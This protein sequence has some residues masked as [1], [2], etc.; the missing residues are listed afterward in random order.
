MQTDRTLLCSP[1]K[2]WQENILT[3]LTPASGALQLKGWWRAQVNKNTRAH[4]SPRVI[5]IFGFYL[6]SRS[7]KVWNIGLTSFKFYDLNDILYIMSCQFSLLFHFYLSIY[8][9]SFS[10]SISLSIP[11]FYN[12]FFLF[13]IRYICFFDKRFK[14]CP[15]KDQT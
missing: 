15:W 1:V 14:F 9:P 8:F 13:S 6:T 10:L 5:F 7:I 4:S 12:I 2:H 11:L 3:L